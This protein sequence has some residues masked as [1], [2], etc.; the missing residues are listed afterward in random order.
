[1][2]KCASF[3]STEIKFR[4]IKPEQGSAVLNETEGCNMIY[5]FHCDGLNNSYDFYVNSLTNILLCST[6]EALFMLYDNR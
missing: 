6:S 1:M 5:T 2:A 4:T 3:P